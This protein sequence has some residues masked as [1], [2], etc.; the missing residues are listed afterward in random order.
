MTP[1]TSKY[2]FCVIQRRADGKFSGRDDKWGDIYHS[3]RF[4]GARAER[5][6]SINATLKGIEIRN[7]KKF[8]R[9]DYR[10]LNVE[11]FF[12][13]STV[14]IPEEFEPEEPHP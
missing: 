9:D 3:R 10:I 14:E 12:S 11:A 2:S 8:K 6:I 4:D 5:A 1:N 13:F 7:K